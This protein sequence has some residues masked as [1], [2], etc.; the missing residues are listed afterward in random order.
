MQKRKNILQWPHFHTKTSKTRT[1]IKKCS[2]RL[3]FKNPL[4]QTYLVLTNSICK[5]KISYKNYEFTPT[6]KTK[7]QAEIVHDHTS[8][9]TNPQN[10]YAC[11]TN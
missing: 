4:K 10:V 6:N 9:K 1:I 5:Q 7:L 11:D 8:N 2:A 3:V